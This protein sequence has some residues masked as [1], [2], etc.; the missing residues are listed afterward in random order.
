[1]RAYYD[2][3]AAGDAAPHT[4]FTSRRGARHF[5]RRFSHVRIQAEN[6]DNLRLAGRWLI[7]R[8]R[9]IEGPVARL[10]GLDFYITARK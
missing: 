6:I 7:R 1:M 4:D 3:N 5:L 2:T 9:L 10:F 8:G